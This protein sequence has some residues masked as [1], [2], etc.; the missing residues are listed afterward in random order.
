MI[1]RRTA[2]VSFIL[3]AALALI[4]WLAL[5][6]QNP[7]PQTYRNSTYGIS[8]RLPADY[9]VT[10]QPNTNPP[11]ENGIADIIEFADKN[12]SLQLAISYAS[13]ASP[14]LTTE[15]LLSNYPYISGIQI[16]P[17]PIA[18]GETGLALDDD[19]SRPSQISDV[20]F[21]RNGYLYQLT[22]F[23]DGFR[24]LMP[25]ARTIILN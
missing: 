6:P 24:E 2:I 5:R 1:A 25:V 3:L 4:A 21:A 8:L 22:A 9:T 11:Q 10:E 23:G 14:V 19:R 12:G 18:S 17:F 13:Y 7:L 16:Q 15:S 20:W